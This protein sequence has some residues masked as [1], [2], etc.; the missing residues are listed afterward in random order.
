ML[1]HENQLTDEEAFY[2][3]THYL[4]SLQL[5]VLIAS[6]SVCYEQHNPVL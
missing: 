6:R 4:F 1:G 3:F 2:I 5:L